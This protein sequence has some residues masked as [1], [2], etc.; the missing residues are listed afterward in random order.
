MTRHY[1][2]RTDATKMSPSRYVRRRRPKPSKIVIPTYA[3]G[4]RHP[5]MS[6][7]RALLIM[8]GSKGGKKGKGYRWDSASARKAILKC[9]ATRWR[10]NKTIGHRIGRSPRNRPVVKR[11]P[12]RDQYA[13]TP[14]LG[15]RYA[16]DIGWHLEATGEC[17]SERTALERLGHLPSHSAKH[18]IPIAIREV[19]RPKKP[20]VRC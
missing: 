16:G 18:R 5:I 7:A 8:G 11:Q 14:R 4:G 20:H 12:L 10:F 13:L 6:R 2:Y 19:A 17:L 1:L 9:W 3:D 15:I